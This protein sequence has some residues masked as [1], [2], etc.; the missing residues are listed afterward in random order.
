MP[1][2][3]RKLLAR[4]PAG[5]LLLP[6]LL[7]SATEPAAG[8]SFHSIDPIGKLARVFNRELVGIEDRISWLEQRLSKIAP[9]HEH[10][11][12]VAL[13]VRCG[14]INESDPDPSVTIDLGAVHPLDEI[15]L[16]P[17]QREYLEDPGLF[18]KKFTIECSTEEDFSRRT[19]LFTSGSRIFPIPD[20]K[21]VRFT[22]SGN[23][24]RFVRI[25][26]HQGHHKGM[27][28]VFGLSELIAVS[29]G[30]PVSFGATVSTVGAL[31]VTGIWFPEALTDGHTPLGIWHNGT[32]GTSRGDSITTNGT[33]DEPVFWIL[34]LEEE[35]PVDRVVLF[36][37]Q[38][39]EL[40][41]SCVLPE[42]FT[43][44]ATGASGG[45][46]TLVYRWETPLSGANRMT[47]LVIPMNGRPIKHLRFTGTR[48]W[49]MG[50]L[51]VHAVSEIE[52]WSRGENVALGRNVLR[53]QADGSRTSIATLTDG[54]SNGRQIIPVAAWLNQLHERWRL[55]QELAILRP[56]GRQMAGKSEIKAT[57]GS[58]AMLAFS[59]LI[60]VFIVERRRV[61][62]RKQLDQLRRRIASDLHDDIGS[63]LG[64][65]S[66]IARTARKDLVRLKGPEE[67]A[68]DLG[69][70][71]SIAR[72]SSLAMRDIVWLLER[73]EDS[74]GDLVKRMR[75]TAGRLLRE[76]DYTIDCESNK[77]AA[78][79][80]LDA[81]R[82]LFLFY[83]EAIHNIL[84][85]SRSNRV[86]IRLWDDHD[87]LALEIADNGIGL[88]LGPDQRP[89]NVRKLT[90]RARVLEANLNIQSSKDEGTRIRLIVKR[91]QLIATPSL[92]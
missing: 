77:T 61:Q 25:T 51:Q 42:S 2:L 16:I 13:G 32:S 12:R 48:P 80:S 10:A 46:E 9:H 55:E 64:S 63:N 23:D 44:H 54:Y 37:Y 65:I 40:L 49:Q 59:F 28:D 68:D 17:T 4:C 66:L 43:L 5:N 70:V 81:K 67:V 21:P 83:K 6:V 92:S 56:L 11:M 73:R 18:P 57:W 53:L 91:S 41:E 62:S 78:K 8:E 88:P 1:N 24:A 60:P 7:L 75:E 34:E 30:D 90:D 19:V 50:D 35:K 3:P 52:V 45:E 15:F 86:A 72:E 82:H 85:H 20:G 33:S 71:E 74:I 47:P 26:V 14:R 31:N 27:R 79:L 39:T 76:I 22:G 38:L 29:A 87:K 69:E 58:A 36:P 84:K 89:A